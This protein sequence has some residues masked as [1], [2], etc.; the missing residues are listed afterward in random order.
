MIHVQK[1]NPGWMDYFKQLEAAA[2]YRERAM[3]RKQ[4]YLAAYDIMRAREALATAK[5][6]RLQ[7]EAYPNMGRFADISKYYSPLMSS[8]LFE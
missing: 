7:L 2:V 3:K 1:T 4:R 5:S 6:V 8:K